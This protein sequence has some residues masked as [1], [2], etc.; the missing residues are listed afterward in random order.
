MIS[1]ENLALPI[2]LTLCHTPCSLVTEFGCFYYLLQLCDN[3]IICVSEFSCAYYNTITV[4]GQS[5]DCNMIHVA[6]YFI[7]FPKNGV[8]KQ[9]LVFLKTSPKNLFK[10]H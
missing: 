9:T 4:Y 10:I 7:R 3:E 1:C 2:L 5:W 8:L 6:N